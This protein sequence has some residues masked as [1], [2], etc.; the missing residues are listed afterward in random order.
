MAGRDGPPVADPADDDDDDGANPQGTRP[1]AWR[2]GC[3]AAAA[4][5]V[6]SSGAPPP[7]IIVNIDDDDDDPAVDGRD[8]RTS[9]II[10]IDRVIE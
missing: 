9:A 6:P 5:P 1:E 7:R 10:A 3:S 4:M 8:R 2:C